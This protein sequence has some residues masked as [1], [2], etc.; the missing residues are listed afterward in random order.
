MHVKDEYSWWIP[1]GNT[2]NMLNAALSAWPKTPP[3]TSD[4][5]L[6]YDRIYNLKN[7]ALQ[8]LGTLVLGEERYRTAKNATTFF[9]LYLSALT[10]I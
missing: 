5:T 1:T 4:A 6:C 10:S 7:L 9:Y 8:P 2:V 3:Q